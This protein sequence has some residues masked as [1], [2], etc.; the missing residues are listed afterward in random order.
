LR[1]GTHFEL[2]S[3]NVIEPFLTE[4]IKRGAD[5]PDVSK[6]EEVV[7]ALFLLFLLSL[8]TVGGTEKD[9]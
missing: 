1:N 8:E 9:F 2:L 5:A 6:A 4:G 3:N 7:Q